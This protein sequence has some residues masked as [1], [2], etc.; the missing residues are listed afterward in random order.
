[1]NDS[2]KQLKGRKL[3]CITLRK[4]EGRKNRQEKSGRGQ[5]RVQGVLNTMLPSISVILLP[6]TN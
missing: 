5:A 1:M 6:R 2:I 4:E 3:N